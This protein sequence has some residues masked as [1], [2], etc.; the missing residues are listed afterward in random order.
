MPQY[1]CRA[2]GAPSSTKFCPEHTAA[3]AIKLQEKERERGSAWARGYNTKWTK[4][5]AAFLRKHPYCE[6]CGIP[7][8]DVHHI[9]GKGPK[10]KRGHDHR[11]LQ[12]L[13]HSHHSQITARDT[14]L[15]QARKRQD[16]AQ[17]PPR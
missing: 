9:D 16:R 11:N 1:A 6:V 7:A 8:T 14:A 13:C 4:T 15:R 17:T 2:C 10:G 12:A 5:R 3:R